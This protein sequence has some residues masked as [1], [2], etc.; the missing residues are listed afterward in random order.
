MKRVYQVD[1]DDD[2]TPPSND[3]QQQQQ[4]QQPSSLAHARAHTA[5]RDDLFEEDG[6]LATTIGRLPMFSPEGRFK[7]DWTVLLAFLLLYICIAVPL[8][9]GFELTPIGMWR[10]FEVSNDFFLLWTSQ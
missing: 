6:C 5:G 3:T 9:M 8:Q 4:R 10:Y 7:I 1:D 2:K